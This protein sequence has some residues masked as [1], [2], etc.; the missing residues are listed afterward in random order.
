MVKIVVELSEE[1]AKAV[2]D[3]VEKNDDIAD[4]A[5]FDIPCYQAAAKFRRAVHDQMQESE[6]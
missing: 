5:K 2:A 6:E 1:E 4:T 3:G